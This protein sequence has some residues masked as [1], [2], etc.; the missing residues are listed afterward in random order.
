MYITESASISWHS[1]PGPFGH[2]QSIQNYTPKGKVNTVS[3]RTL[4]D[5]F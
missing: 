1:N 3:S 2:S 4:D 5:F